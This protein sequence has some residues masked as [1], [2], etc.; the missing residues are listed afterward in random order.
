MTLADLTLPM[1]LAECKDLALVYEYA[2]AVALYN[3]Q[4]E[5]GDW[6]HVCYGRSLVDGRWM[7]DG[8]ILSMLGHGGIYGWVGKH[9]DAETMA[10]VAI[11]PLAEAEM[12]L[13]PPPAYPPE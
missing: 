5:H 8:Q 3:L 13:V 4:Q 1:P 9:M 7:I 10:Q 12:L 2:V 11:L 6:R